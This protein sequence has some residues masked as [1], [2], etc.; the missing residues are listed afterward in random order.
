MRTTAQHEQ[1]VQYYF[2]KFPSQIEFLLKNGEF[3][4]RQ[5]AL[6]VTLFSA[7][8][9]QYYVSPNTI[10]YSLLG[11]EK[12]IVKIRLASEVKRKQRDLKQHKT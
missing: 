3:G 8:E 10:W 6:K 1:E 7:R 9:T 11:K 2:L 4:I 5:N 12:K